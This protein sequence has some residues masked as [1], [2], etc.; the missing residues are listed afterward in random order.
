M[1]GLDLDPASCDEANGWIKAGEIFTREQ[2]GYTKRWRGRVFL[3]PPGGLSDNLQRPVKPKCRLTGACGLP[4]GHAH[5]GVESS[6]KKWWFKLAHEVDV[7]NVSDA[8]FVCFSVELLQN[9]QV[10]TPDDLSIPLEWP[11]CYPSRRVAYVKPGGGIGSQPP[12]ASCI[13]GVGSN[14]RRFEEAFA[15]LG[16]VVVPDQ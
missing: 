8:V 7:G 2:D 11:I 9:T 1:G 16:H 13:I 14:W 4:A 15:P 3:N 6:Q 12:H 5:E 10:D